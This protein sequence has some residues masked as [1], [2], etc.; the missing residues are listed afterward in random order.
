MDEAFEKWMS[1]T[2]HWEWRRHQTTGDM[3]RT[4]A[5]GRAAERADVLKEVQDR[6]RACNYH[7]TESELI[8]LEA[9]LNARGES[10][11]EEHGRG[12]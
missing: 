9:W 7:V 6:I 4:F 10:A 2:Q 8:D 11:K 12:V 1:E 5:A 3:E